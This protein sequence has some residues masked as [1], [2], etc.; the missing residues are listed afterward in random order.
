MIKFVGMCAFNGLAH[1]KQKFEALVDTGAQCT[2]MPSGYKG[3]KAICI[4][5][6]TGESQELT[7]GTAN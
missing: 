1:Q 5:G 2:L 6:V 3:A 4:P 7:I